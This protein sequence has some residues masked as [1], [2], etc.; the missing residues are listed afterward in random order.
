M[1]IDRIDYKSISTKLIDMLKADDKFKDVNFEA[2]GVKTFINMLAYNTHY[3][4]VYMYMLNN[5]SSIDSAQLKQTIY[6]KSRGLGYYPRHKRAARA[7]VI[8]KTNPMDY[9]DDGYVVFHRFKNIVGTSPRDNSTRFFSNPDD[10]YLYDYEEDGSGKYIFSSDPTVI[11]E[12]KSDIWNFKVD[13]SIEYQTFIIKDKT[14]DIDTLRVFV[15]ESEDDVG[16][17][18]KHADTVFDLTETSN[19][20]Y[21]TTTSDGYYQVFFGN[22]VFGKQPDDGMIIS[23]EYVSTNGEEGNGC[24]TFTFPGFKFVANEMSNSGS[25]GE[26]LENVKFNAVNHFK[27]QNRLSI[28]DD[29][30]SMIMEHFRNIKAINIWGGEDHYQKMYGKIF[31]SIKPVY[32]DVLSESAKK[33]IR[34]KILAKTEKLG[35]DPLFVDPEF[36]DCHVDIVLTTNLNITNESL[37]DVQNA[38]IS[39]CVKYN[40]EY[41]NIFNNK[42]IDLDLNNMIK[43][44]SVAI[45]GVF[46]RK[47]LFKTVTIDNA[48]TSEYSVYFGNQI[49]QGTVE[50]TLSVGRYN[51]KITDVNGVLVATD[52]LE[53]EVKFNIGT[54]DYKAGTIKFKNP[55]RNYS[56]INKVVWKCIPKNPDVSSLLNNI[57]R[58]TKARI[59]DE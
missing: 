30:R 11:M 8:I 22:N 53:Q 32:A 13:K 55:I 27:S 16:V 41:L 50:S 56:G 24:S 43:N 29:F 19:I 48:N 46:N 26:S 51:L 5:E 57:V 20:F 23:C 14:I 2:S 31:I 54:V 33:E 10:V 34:N 4:G 44:S 21:I 47:T 15:K 59:V 3:L 38:A 6:S 1:N 37:S 12:G 36:I 42:L 39:A 49:L 40:N 17:T 52:K 28:K 7:E 9:P 58:I 18:F 25:D 35:A 45:G